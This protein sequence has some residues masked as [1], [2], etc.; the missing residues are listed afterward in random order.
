MSIGAATLADIFDP[1]VRGK[2]VGIDLCV[3]LIIDIVSKL[4]IYYIAPLLGPVLLTL[5]AAKFLIYF[6]GRLLGRYLEVYWRRLSIGAP[7]S[8]SLL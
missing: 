6:C 7:F 2:K 8:G 5:H 4:G 1:A 3:F